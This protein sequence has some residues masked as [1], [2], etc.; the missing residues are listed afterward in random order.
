[1]EPDYL[2]S[3]F[4][5]GMYD[6]IEHLAFHSLEST[7]TERKKKS[8]DEDENH[9]IILTK[10]IFSFFLIEAHSFLHDEVNYRTQ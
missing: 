9:H 2:L 3:I 5:R 4:C 7:N 8:R 10:D 6:T 1:M